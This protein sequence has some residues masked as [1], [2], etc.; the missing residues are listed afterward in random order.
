MMSDVE[1]NEAVSVTHGIRLFSDILL[2]SET[3]S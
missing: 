1:A 2:T 3:V